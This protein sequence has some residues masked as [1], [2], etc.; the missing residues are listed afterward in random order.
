MFQFLI[1]ILQVKCFLLNTPH[2]SNT[3]IF[4]LPISNFFSVTFRIDDFT[5]CLS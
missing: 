1:F 3:M 5:L 2:I 4:K